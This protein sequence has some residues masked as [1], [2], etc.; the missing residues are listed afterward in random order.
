MPDPGDQRPI[1]DPTKLTQEASDRLERKLQHEIAA[2]QELVL[3]DVHA[4][5][6]LAMEKF[7]AIEAHRL[8]QKAD[9]AAALAAALKAVTDESA[10][11]AA[12]TTKQIDSLKTTFDTAIAGL[13]TNLN[14]LKDRMT[15]AEGNTGGQAQARAN[16]QAWLSAAVAV[17]VILG[18]VFALRGR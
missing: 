3:R 5:D 13:T 11:T 16:L 6:R 14:D 7:R 10:K 18:F 2:N 15:K 1:P 8:E 4:L 12:S 9:G 17:I